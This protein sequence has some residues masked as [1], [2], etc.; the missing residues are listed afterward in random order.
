MAL[1]RSTPGG[2]NTTTPRLS[3][4]LIGVWKRVPGSRRAIWR[5]TSAA[6]E[7]TLLF[8]FSF[9]IISWN[10]TIFFT[11]DTL[12]SS[13]CPRASYLPAASSSP[14]P[15]PTMSGQISSCCCLLIRKI[16]ESSL[17]KEESRLFILCARCGISMTSWILLLIAGDDSLQAMFLRHQQSLLDHHNSCRDLRNIHHGCG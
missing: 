3:S 2:E 9:P 11:A 8:T 17:L 5:F 14:H 16:N 7:R 6:K 15:I 12:A 4:S 1:P 13:L 10:S